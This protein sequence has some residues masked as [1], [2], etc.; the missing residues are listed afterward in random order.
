MP[1]TLAN[2]EDDPSP[3][4]LMTVGKTSTA[5]T[6]TCS[7]HAQRLTLVSY[8]GKRACDGESAD[9]GEGGLAEGAGD[10]GHQEQGEAP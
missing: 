4:L 5:Y 8:H 1:P 6:N 7:T 9:L 3:T 2:T 10:G